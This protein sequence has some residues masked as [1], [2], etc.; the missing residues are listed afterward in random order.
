MLQRPEYI[1]PAYCPICDDEMEFVGTT[2]TG[3]AQFLCSDC[4]QRR[5]QFVG[6]EAID[7]YRRTAD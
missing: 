2:D 1:D 6:M 3:L 4:K 5:E 7:R